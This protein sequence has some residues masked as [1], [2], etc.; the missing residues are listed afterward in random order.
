[1]DKVHYVKERT[2]DNHVILGDTY[3]CEWKIIDHELYVKGATSIYNNWFATGDIVHVDEDN[4]MYYKC[5]K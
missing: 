1:M 5:R 2:P 4:V 3:Y